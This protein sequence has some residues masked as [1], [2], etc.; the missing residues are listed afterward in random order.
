MIEVSNPSGRLIT[1]RVL[2]P[3]EDGNAEAAA[4]QL[5]GAIGRLNGQIIVCTD[6]TD[7]RTFAPATTERFV[8]TMKADNPRLERSA[9]LL[10]P[11]SPTLLLQ[12][13]RMVRESNHPARRTFRDPAELAEWLRPV[14]SADE[15]RALEAFLRSAAVSATE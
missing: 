9:I 6:L 12:L 7:A 2:S 1:F 4:T 11:E 13:E 8:Q 5:R 14:L 3:V 15:Q 10:G